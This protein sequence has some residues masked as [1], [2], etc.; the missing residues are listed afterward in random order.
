[1]FVLVSSAFSSVTFGD[2]VHG[3]NGGLEVFSSR[4][5]CQEWSDQDS[6]K[7]GAVVSY[8]G[9]NYTA[10]VDIKAYPGANWNPTVDNRWVAGGDCG[11]NPSPSPSPTD[12]PAPGTCQEWTDQLSFKAGAVVSYKGKSY[13]ARVDIKAYPGANWNPT[14]DN[15]WVAGGTCGVDP[16]PSPSP[17]VTPSPSPSVTP[18]PTPTV[19]PSPTPTVSPVPDDVMSTDGFCGNKNITLN[20][21][22][23]TPAATPLDSMGKLFVGYFSTWFDRGVHPGEERQTQLANIA[24]Y[25]NVVNVSFMKPDAVYTKG[26]LSLTSTGV[27]YAS[28]GVVLK[29]AIGLLKAKGTKVLI[30][31]GGATYPNFANLNVQAIQD[32]VADF[33]FDGVDIDFESSSNCTWASGGQTCTGDADYVRAITTLRAALPRPLILATAAWSVGAYGQGP[34]VCDTPL[35]SRTGMLINPLLTAGQHLDLINVM[36]YDAGIW[37]MGTPQR[38]DQQTNPYY[39][40]RAVQAY[41]KI[42]KGHIVGGI[43]V[44]YEAWGGNATT[45]DQVRQY[46]TFIMNNSVSGLMLWSLQGSGNGVGPL[47]PQQISTQICSSLNM[48]NCTAPLL[49]GF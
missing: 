29:A 21:P 2:M 31:V 39:P 42:F 16:S 46:G 34:F 19:T 36:S 38:S 27:T 28:G 44:P 18:S 6:F 25:V 24:P 48:S 22:S 30:S 5:A 15:R 4:M 8:M 43:E 1:M 40:L 3:N 13:T 35:V 32:F 45:L 17:S 23:Y 33:G 26:S 37:N 41:Q 9:K 10:R 20:A 12:S 49:G 11:T 7:A 14:V 47:T